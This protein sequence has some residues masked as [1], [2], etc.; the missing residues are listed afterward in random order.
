LSKTKV[1]HWNTPMSKKIVRPKG[2][3]SKE[4]KILTSFFPLFFPSGSIW[5]NSNVATRIVIWHLRVDQTSNFV[6]LSFVVNNRLPGRRSDCPAPQ[7]PT[8]PSAPSASGHLMCPSA[9]VAGLLFFAVF[10]IS[11]F[12]FFIPKPYFGRKFV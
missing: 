10:K 9:I 6:K 3:S 1:K 5:C 2:I 8:R 7:L 4:Y 11:N 12:K